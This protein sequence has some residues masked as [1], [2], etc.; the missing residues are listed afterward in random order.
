MLHLSQLPTNSTLQFTICPLSNL[1]F[2]HCPG[3]GLGKSISM[4]LHGNIFDSFDFHLLG[5]PAL[6]IILLFR[7]SQLIKINYLIHFKTLNKGVNHA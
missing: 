2:E 6:I 1:G 3:C 4:I 7:I 5:I